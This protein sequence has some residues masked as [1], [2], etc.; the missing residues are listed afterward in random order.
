MSNS[1][2]VVG[3]QLSRKEAEQHQSAI[4]EITNIIGGAC[5]HEPGELITGGKFL[6]R[7]YEVSFAAWQAEQLIAVLL[8]C[9][10]T[11]DIANAQVKGN[12]FR[13]PA[14][15]FYLDHLAVR[16]EFQRGGLG[17]QLMDAW[18]VRTRHIAVPEDFDRID[19]A[20]EKRGT[21]ETAHV[22]RFYE[23][24]GFV[25]VGH[26]QYGSH[27]DAVMW[28]TEQL[29]RNAMLAGPQKDPR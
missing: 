29:S 8:A 27:N 1:D 18:L 12:N 9:W 24:Y 22:R 17:S 26:R 15:L 14:A 16:P 28:R 3:K 7:R 21:K 19:W 2:T 13:Y 23:K 25:V 4:D 10:R 11:T 6:P 5:S 20:L